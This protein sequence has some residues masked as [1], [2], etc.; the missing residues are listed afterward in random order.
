MKIDPGYIHARHHLPNLFDSQRKYSKAKH[1]YHQVLKQQPK[2]VEA[3]ANLSSILEKEHQ[4]AEA[5][6]FANR[7]LEINPDHFVA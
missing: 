2:F 6:S 3:L 1:L 5:R 4:L 7:A